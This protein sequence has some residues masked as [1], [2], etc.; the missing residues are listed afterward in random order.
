MKAHYLVWILICSV[1]R[2]FAGDVPNIVF[3]TGE[4]E[5]HSKE[6]FPEFARG[7][8]QDYKVKTTILQ[9]PDDEKVQ[10]ISG[11]EKLA[12][13]DLVILMMRRMVLPEDQMALI[14]K[15]LDSGKPLIGLRTASHSFEN[16]K[17]FD[18]EV[19]GGNYG[20]HFENDRKTTVTIMPEARDN[21]ILRGVTSFVSDG[22]LYRNTPL[23]P[24]SKPLLIGSAM[25]HPP[26]PVAWTHEYKSG[27]IFYS[28]LGHPNDFKEQSFQNLL[29]HAIEWALNTPLQKRDVK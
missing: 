16:W 5:Y 4:F 17:E 6:T 25:G 11:L 8:E 9:R 1:I 14:K 26:Q 15:Y 22:A 28:S 21:P 20:N 7:L 29:H 27:R 18:R 12:D 10:S 3:I 24:G 13:A 19:L 23:Q 2:C